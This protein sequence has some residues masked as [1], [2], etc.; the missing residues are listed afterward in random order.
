[1]KSMIT[2]SLPRD[3]RAQLR[4]VLRRA[5]HR[6]IGGVLMGEQLA[7]SHFRIVN[8][9][10]DEISGTAAHFVRSPE[11]HQSALNEFFTRTGSDYGRF[12]YLGEWHSH[13]NF[14]VRPSPTDVQSMVNLVHSERDIAFAAL[15]IV[16]LRFLV[17]LELSCHMFAHGQEPKLVALSY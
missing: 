11:H 12:N 13:P 1:M 7:P 17:R 9:S 2:I 15:M 4:A 10:I 6:E 8:L 14:P 3:Q 5:G 16:R